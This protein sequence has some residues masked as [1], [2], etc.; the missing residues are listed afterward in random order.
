[1]KKLLYIF[2]IALSSQAF[3]QQT[4]NINLLVTDQNGSPIVN[5]LVSIKDGPNATGPVFNYFT[6]ANGIVN[7]SLGVQGTNFL[8]ATTTLNGCSDSSFFNYG[9]APGTVLFYTDTLQ[10]CSAAVNCNFAFGNTAQGS[11]L[12]TYSFWHQGD[13]N[14]AT[15]WDFGDGNTS[16]LSAPTHVYSANGT[17]VYCVT[18]AGCPTVCDT[19][20]ISN[21]PPPASCQA[22]FIIDTVNSQPGA[23]VIWNNSTPIYSPNSNTTYAWNFGD[24]ST[25]TQ[26]FPSH[27]Y[28]IA[29]TYAICL[30]I[31]VPPS[32]IDSGCTSTFC[33][34]LSVDSLGNIIYKTGGTGF[35]IN[36]LNPNTIS[37]NEHVAT[38][39]KLYP[40]PAN[41]IIKIDFN[42]NTNGSLTLEI[43]DINGRTIVS[44][45]ENTQDGNNNIIMDISALESGIYFI[46]INLDG[47][48]Y[49]E[50]ILKQ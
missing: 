18:V 31:T 34:T 48:T 35:T 12:M 43:L 38:E 50:K 26:P 25:S 42:T 36:V 32:P 21:L 24:G 22:S 28:S 5:Q 14:A 8:M 20:I 37:I 45:N 41:D 49:Y 11:S 44:K 6:N 7:D 47:E 39:F 4:I 40:N 3:A 15:T 13:P 2:I 27:A 46:K 10:L 33:D 29:G 1:M 16:N 17:Y 19:L 23:V 30:T 9:G